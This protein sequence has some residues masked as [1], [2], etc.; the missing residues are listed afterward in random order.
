MR[1]SEE[2]N[3]DEDEP[4]SA[5]GS[6]YGG[7]WGIYLRAPDL[8]FEL[9]DRVGERFKPLGE[10]AEIWRGVTSGKDEFFYPRDVSAECLEKFPAFHEFRQKFGVR[11]EDV[12]SGEVRL[13]RCGK[14]YGEI[15]PIE[16]K[17]ME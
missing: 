14:S 10:V 15:R 8:W 7:K 9:M 2:E 6:Y 5:V 4:G 1:G 16:A 13:V 3:G 11:R 12:E 17:Y